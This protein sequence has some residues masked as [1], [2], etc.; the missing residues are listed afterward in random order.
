MPGTEMRF[1]FPEGELGA[2]AALGAITDRS[3]RIWLR[4]PEGGSK[5]AVLSLEGE[6]A[7]RVTLQP[8]ADHD[9]IATAELT[10][11]R[12]A[13]NAP[14]AV[15]LPEKPA[16]IRRG[17]LAP[18]PGS[19]VAFSFAFGSCHQPF[20][21]RRRGQLVLHPGV[22]IY[23]AMARVLRAQAA[24]FLI[25]L[26]DQIYSDAVRPIRT[27]LKRKAGSISDAE[28]LDVYRHIYRGYFNEAGFRA[29]LEEWPACFIWD[30]HD[31]FQGWGSRLRVDA[32]DRRLFR[33]AEQSYR[34]YQH[35]RNPGA[36]LDDP[37]PHHYSFWFGDT[38]F[39][40][41]DLRGVR[42]YPTG[43][44]LGERQRRDFQ[45]FLAEAGE[46]GAA[47]LFIV[48]SVPIVHF[49]RGL[50]RLTERIPGST[51]S[52]VRD[53]WSTTP[54]DGDRQLVLESLF[55]W[56][57]AHSDRQV[58]VLSGDV[59][60]GARFRIRRRDGPGT[61]L[62]WTS[63]SLSSPVH[64]KLRLINWM[65]T[66]LPLWGERRYRIDRQALIFHNNFGL[67]DVIPL[68]SGGHQVHLTLYAYQPQNQTLH[69]G[70]R[71][72]GRPKGASRQSAE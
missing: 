64:L 7:A 19:R 63:S 6:M 9:W 26:G 36:G 70:D 13:P 52:G 8:S 18:A 32:F 30:D 28:I 47:T 69:A 25:L 22:G 53:R 24:R 41:F 3:V 65:G 2:S 15:Q 34:E 44:L 27:N 60:A 1:P 51:G 11:D 40:V 58:I 12:P 29:L 10:L 33:A 62:Q 46:R 43:V 23:P 50:V 5:D 55:D 48:A 16:M 54:F 57:A 71:A 39:F 61:I 31:I 59:H 49:A 45:R 4:D 67:V 72:V 56:Q 14:F 66:R 17:R 68:E 38:G 20:E 35:L 42:D 37:A 21:K